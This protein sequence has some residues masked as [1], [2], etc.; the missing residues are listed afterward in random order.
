MAGGIFKPGD[1]V[2]VL[3]S[4][5]TS[6]VA[7]VRAPGGEPLAEAFPPQSVTLPLTDDLDIGRGDMICRP[8]NRPLRRPGH[9]RHGVLVRRPV[10]ARG[11]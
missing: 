6:R 1:E 4:G 5:F 9:R 8:H 2:V 3:P 10:V 7:E 11:R